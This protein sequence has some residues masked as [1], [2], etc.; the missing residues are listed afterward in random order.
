MDRDTI[1]MP[2]KF[3]NDFNFISLQHRVAEGDTQ[4]FRQIFDILFAN[5]T[6]FSFSFVQSKEAATEVVDEIF[7]QLWTKRQDILKIEDLR[8]Y[9]YTATKNASLNYLKKRAKQI[10]L[11]PYDHLQVQIADN[12]SPEQ[13]MISKETILQIKQAIESLPPRCKL[14][15]K[16][17]RE[18]GLKYSEVAEILNLSHKTIDSQ[19]V[20][21]ISRIKSIIKDS[22]ET[23]NHKVFLKK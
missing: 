6:G 13:L 17:V 19:M 12:N 5:L 8:V 22:L 9:L 21:A 3:N 11:E 18:D 23:N 7:V 14:I 2:N 4:A 20:I 1:A 16:L 10:Q 15:F